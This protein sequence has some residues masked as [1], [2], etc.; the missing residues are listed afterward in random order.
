MGNHS[1]FR[2]SMVRGAPFGL[3][4]GALCLLFGAVVARGD[5]RGN[6]TV[7]EVRRIGALR[8]LE[9]RRTA[10]PSGLERI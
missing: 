1:K 8:S 2:F 6:Q 10:L 7:D 9:V 3:M 5:V 4:F